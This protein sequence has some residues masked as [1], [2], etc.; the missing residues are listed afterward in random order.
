MNEE[1]YFGMQINIKA[2]Y[3]LIL[4]ILVFSARHAQGT[5]N[6]NFVYICNISG[7][8]WEMKSN[9]CLQINTKVFY[10]LI[11]WIW[12]CVPRHAQSTQNNKFAIS[13]QYL[14]ENVK[15]EV[16]FLPVDKGQ[17]FPEI[18][19]IILSFQFFCDTLRK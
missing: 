6:K 8:A 5:Q 10:K 1:A 4:S 17:K 14:K 18:Y 13:L 15:D 7:K 2:F 12:V 11:V 19:T 16:Y 3:N 9:L